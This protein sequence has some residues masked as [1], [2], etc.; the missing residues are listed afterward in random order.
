MGEIHDALR[1]AD[2]STDGSVASDRS[3]GHRTDPEI[4][5]AFRSLAPE[6]TRAE[7]EAEPQITLSEDKHGRWQSREVIVDARGPA[8]ESL[9]HLALRLRRELQARGVR[10]VALLS[11]LRA[12]GKTTLACNLALALASLDTGRGVALVDLD[13]RKPQVAQSFE[14]RG[15]AGIEAVLAGRIGLRDACTSIA[16]PPL[17]VYPALR[18]EQDAHLV[19]SQPSLGPLV[20][21]L[22]REYEIVVVDTPPVLLVPDAL[23]ILEAVKS[24]VIVGRARRST[25]GAVEAMRKMIPKERLIGAVLNEGAL[26]VRAGHYGYYDEELPEEA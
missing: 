21:Q 19:L 13:L 1:R 7:R 15:G 6:R 18:T 16:S 23:I 12:E 11:A 25:G 17:D 5:E 10:S 20:R 4:L 14:I 26:P 24:A 9:R 22:E 3:K 8:A 2:L